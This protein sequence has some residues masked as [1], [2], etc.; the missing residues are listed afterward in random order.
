M[1]EDDK[2]RCL[3]IESKLDEIPDVDEVVLPHYELQHSMK[4]ELEDINNH[5][6]IIAKKNTNISYLR[7]CHEN[8][9][10]DNNDEKRYS[11]LNSI[12]KIQ[13]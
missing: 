10:E 11:I 12:L 4:T 9:L 1:P 2:L 3:H 7:P 8:D 13:L 6:E 5:Y